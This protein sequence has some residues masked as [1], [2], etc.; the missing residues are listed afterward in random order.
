MRQAIASAPNPRNIN[1]AAMPQFTYRGPSTDAVR[2]KPPLY[3]RIVAFLL[4]LYAQE[5]QRADS[6]REHMNASYKHILTKAGGNPTFLQGP[7]IGSKPSTAANKP[8]A[9]VFVKVSYL[10]FILEHFSLMD[11]A[12]LGWQVQHQMGQSKGSFQAKLESLAI[13][14]ITRTQQA[15]VRNCVRYSF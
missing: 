14:Q 8:E 2:F 5:T 4:Y 12:V 6:V 10:L 15:L 1:P 13:W 7:K 11:D 3:F 9:Q